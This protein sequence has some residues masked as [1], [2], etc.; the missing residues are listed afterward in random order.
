VATQHPALRELFS[1]YRSLS[2]DTVPIFEFVLIGAIANA[3]IEM[4][5]T[6]SATNRQAADMFGVI[7]AAAAIAQSSARQPDAQVG[8]DPAH[9]V[10]SRRWR[11]EHADPNGLAANH[12]QLVRP[13]E[14]GIE[15]CELRRILV[16]TIQHDERSALDEL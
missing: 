15:E 7:P 5:N 11:F 4:G 14:H 1:H 10:H 8:A 13:A 16:D 12:E 2:A 9:A 6:P 3:V